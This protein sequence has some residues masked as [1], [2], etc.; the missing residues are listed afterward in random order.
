MVEENLNGL[1]KL[2]NFYLEVKPTL[3]PLPKLID[4]EEIMQILGI[5]QSPELGK[6]INELHEAQLNGDVNTKEEA[7][8][9]IKNY[10]K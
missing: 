3:K 4:G 6:I 8:A 7:V 5:K 9:F 1:N 10:S 2:L